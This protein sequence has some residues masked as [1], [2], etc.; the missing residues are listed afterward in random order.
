MN[1]ADNT[2]PPQESTTNTI[3][4]HS[5]HLTNNFFQHDNKLK[6]PI[7]SLTTNTTTIL[8][9]SVSATKGSNSSGTNNNNRKGK[10]KG[11]PENSK[12]RYRGVRQRSWGKWV[13]E[14]REPRK[15]TRRWLGTFST[16][17]EAARAYDRAA[18]VLYGNRAQLNLQSP[19]NNNIPNSNINNNNNNSMPSSSQSS[20]RSS[21]SSTQTL[22]PLLP[23]P[24]GFN[25]LSSMVAGGSGGPPATPSGNYPIYSQHEWYPSTGLQYPHHIFQHP[26]QKMSLDQQECQNQQLNQNYTSRMDDVGQSFSLFQNSNPTQQETQQYIQHHE[27]QNRNNDVCMYNQSNSFPPDFSSGLPTLSLCSGQP[28]VSS[29][30]AEIGSNPTV[31]DEH[32]DGSPSLWQITDHDEYPAASIWDYSDPF[33]FDF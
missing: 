9:A 7:S 18:I 10:G 33:L 25:F 1:S 29:A 3:H 17:E 8:E 30:A 23:R 31:Y 27:G 11:G 16:A 4:P 20:S 28:E 26:H 19:G 22:R 5:N 6:Q 12:F 15:R 24:S 2:H 21:S 14:I 32:H 13:A